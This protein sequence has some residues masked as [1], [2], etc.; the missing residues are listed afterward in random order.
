MP[1]PLAYRGVLYVLANNGVFDAYDLKSG[2]E[3][4]R[5]RLPLVGAAS[6][7]RPWRRTG[8]SICRTKTATCSS[9]GPDRR[10]NTRDELD[11]RIVDG[12]AGAV[13]RRHVRARCCEPVCDRRE[14]LIAPLREESGRDQDRV[15]SAALRGF[16]AQR[17][18]FTRGRSQFLPAAVWCNVSGGWLGQE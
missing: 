9:S 5:Q 8:R 15:E 2:K 10:S 7:P 6:A 1:T 18:A 11:R 17:S 16:S 3:I 13:R 12:D 14:A 4:Y